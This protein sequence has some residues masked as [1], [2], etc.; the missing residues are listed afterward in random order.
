MISAKLASAMNGR[1]WVESAGIKGQGSTF[2]FRAK[3][4]TVQSNLC[5]HVY[6]FKDAKALVV[7]NSDTICQVLVALLQVVLSL[8]FFSLWKMTSVF[9][10]SG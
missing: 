6:S 5:P 1:M 2:L 10:C 8:L 7:D 3:F 4:G 9:L